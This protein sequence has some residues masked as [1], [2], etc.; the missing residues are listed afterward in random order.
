MIGYIR[1]TIRFIED[2]E[3]IV[4]A[5]TS[6]VG[7]RVLIPSSNETDFAV[8]S[9]IELHIYTQVRE[10]AIELYGFK[11]RDERMLFTKLLTVKNVGAKTALTILNTL[12]PAELQT[13]ILTGDT[14]T[15]KRV[16]GIGNK[17]AQM[18]CVELENVLKNFH[19][20]AATPSTSF[21]IPSK[22]AHADTRS[23]LINL[24]FAEADID[25]VL[26]ELEESGENLDVAGE[27]RWALR[28]IKK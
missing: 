23:A 13:A 18:L 20:A 9:E 1:G 8:G 3:I 11:T 25:R 12:T 27:I 28:N 24:G 16:P 26:G 14:V 5:G 10:D 7:Y 17:A 6:G 19:F 2:R 21:K 4:E 15:L 22:S